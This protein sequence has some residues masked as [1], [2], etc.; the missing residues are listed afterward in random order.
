MYRGSM[1]DISEVAQQLSIKRRIYAPNYDYRVR[2]AVP[3][4]L[5]QKYGNSKLTQE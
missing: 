1:S 5:I 3:I 4:R 2:E